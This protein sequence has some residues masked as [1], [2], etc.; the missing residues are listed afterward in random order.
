[1]NPTPR[2][3]RTAG[4]PSLCSMRT[5]GNLT[6]CGVPQGVKRTLMILATRWYLLEDE[7]PAF[8]PVVLATL[9]HLL[10]EL[11]GG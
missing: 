10:G 2:K 4:W 11:A 8:G 3:Q 7:N 6:A 1:M 9:E 5:D